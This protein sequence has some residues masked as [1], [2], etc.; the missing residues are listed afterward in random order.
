MD[1]V[2]RGWFEPG[3]PPS[4]GEDGWHWLAWPSTGVMMCHQWCP[5]LWLWVCT[6]LGDAAS[7]EEIKHLDY[8]GKAIPPLNLYP[9]MPELRGMF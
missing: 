7:P 3:V 9:K 1:F 5:D 4:S 6:Y 2:G 8:I